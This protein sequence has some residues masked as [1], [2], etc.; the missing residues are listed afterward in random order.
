M[1]KIEHERISGYSFDDVQ[2]DLASGRLLVEGRD[3][4]VPPRPLRLLQVLCDRPGLLVRRAEVFEYLWPNH[5]VATDEALTKIITR[6]R[7]LLGPFGARVVT[8]RGRGV[9]L[10]ATVKRLYKEPL[11]PT[12]LP[13]ISAEESQEE[14]EGNDVDYNDRPTI[15]IVDDAPDCITLLSDL[16]KEEY[17]TKIATNGANALKVA[18]RRP[19]PSLI[20]MDVSMPHMD[21]YDVC[22]K[23]K[24]NPLT[25]DIPV[26]FLSGRTQ[27]EEQARGFA[28][29]AVDYIA[30]PISPPI[31]LARIN[32]H[33]A[34]ARAQRVLLMRNMKLENLVDQRTRQLMRTQDATIL[35]MA[36]LIEARTGGSG[37]H[38]RRIQ[39]YVNLLARALQNHPRFRHELADDR[40]ELLV[41]SAPLHDLGKIAV[42]DRILMKDSPLAPE[43]RAE[44][45]TCLARGGDA[46]RAIEDYLGESDDFLRFA[47]E[48]AYSHREHWDGSGYPEGLAG[49]EIP[50][51]ARLM[52]VADV[53]NAL[54]S[55][56]P[57]RP[58]FSHEE[59]VAIMREG[60]ASHFDPDVLN[61]FLR[62][63]EQFHEVA[64]SFIDAPIYMPPPPEA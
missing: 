47:R 29:G 31:V 16:L 28:A 10:D 15:L 48:M 12:S 50:V 30:K 19:S 26:I 40:I 32:T 37:D 6:L 14:E 1:G 54:V 36:S 25:A 2:L 27:L 4:A 18:S 53:Y 9:R 20:L 64:D 3:V 60:R 11:L 13:A 61:A 41:K 57:H 8:V 35:A 5:Q 7:E 34:L 22:A 24:S 21:G 52:A 55:T 59:A 49:D 51:S 62:I 45:R 23:L 39:K 43:E 58:A 38:L 63:H 44:M 33:L 46:I 17:Q 56:R 42:A